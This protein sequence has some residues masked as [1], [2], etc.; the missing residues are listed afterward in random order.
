VLVGRGLR[1]AA[2]RAMPILPRAVLNETAA[3][4]GVC[5]VGQTN[6][7]EIGALKWR[8]GMFGRSDVRN[9]EHWPCS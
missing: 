3:S 1:V 7:T 9:P 4:Y 2:R 5:K 6:E 8:G